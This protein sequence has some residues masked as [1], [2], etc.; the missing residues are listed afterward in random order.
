MKN[1]YVTFAL[2]SLLIYTSNAQTYIELPPLDRSPCASCTAPGYNP[3]TG[4]PDFI[5]GNGPHPFGGPRT[6][7]NV[8]GSSTSGGSSMAFLLLD[9]TI[10]HTLSSLTP[11]DMY[12]IAVDWKQATYRSRLSY[13]IQGDDLV[14]SIN[15]ASKPSSFT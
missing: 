1:I 6:V 8:N 4:T 3:G 15:N 9:E 7:S 11:G 13:V 12:T 5:T 10:T 2:L 14:I